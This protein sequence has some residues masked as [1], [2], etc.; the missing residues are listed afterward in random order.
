MAGR[1]GPGNNR[2]WT[3]I[4]TERFPDGMASVAAHI[5]S[6]GL[7]PG[8]WLAPHGQSNPQVVK[9]PPGVFLLKPDGTS[10]SSTWEGPYPRGRLDRRP[11]RL[12]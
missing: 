10:A 8:L 11:R 4:N 1:A 9:Q 7:T 12:T 2:D 3:T 5:K 6:L